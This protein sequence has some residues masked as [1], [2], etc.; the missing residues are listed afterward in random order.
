MG[1]AHLHP[2]RFSVEHRPHLE[3][4]FGD[5]QAILDLPK[6]PVALVPPETKGADN[7]PPA[8]ATYPCADE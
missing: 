7:T 2:L 4:V 1:D 8:P 3:I 5:P 6:L